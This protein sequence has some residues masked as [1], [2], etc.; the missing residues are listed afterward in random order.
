MK[1]VPKIIKF[2]NTASNSFFKK[3]MML[4]KDLDN[5]EFINQNIWGKKKEQIKID[6]QFSIIDNEKILT[7]GSKDENR[8]IICKKNF[9]E[10]N[11]F[12]F[13]F[14]KFY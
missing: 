4:K 12:P 7:L 2:P 11:N 9:L 3:K 14:L 1:I 6:I 13:P 10:K 8:F 5:W